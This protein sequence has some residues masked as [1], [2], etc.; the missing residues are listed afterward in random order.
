LATLFEN[1]VA[2]STEVLS[3]GIG[4]RSSDVRQIVVNLLRERGAIDVE[5]ANRL[6]S[7]DYA[8]VR[9]E[10]LQALLSHGRQFSDDEARK[11]VI[12]KSWPVKAIS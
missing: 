6:T 9:F 2:L 12:W 4:H 10:A 5:T 11:T 7:D 3:K 8:A 1:G